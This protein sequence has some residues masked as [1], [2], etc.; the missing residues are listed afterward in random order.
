M[1]L[2]L[3]K[4]PWELEEVW[5][6]R[7]SR[8]GSP[9]GA[10]SQEG[11]HGAAGLDGEAVAALCPVVVELCGQP[12]AGLL[13]GCRDDVGSLAELEKEVLDCQHWGGCQVL[14]KR[15]NCPGL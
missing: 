10:A 15:W 13:R 3:P 5:L 7:V 14:R 8:S 6:R 12:W 2:R 11:G 9:G 4:K 1:S